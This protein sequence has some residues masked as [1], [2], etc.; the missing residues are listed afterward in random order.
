MAEY[1]TIFNHKWSKEVLELVEGTKL[2]P[3]MLELMMNWRAAV[4]THAFPGMMMKALVGLWEGTLRESGFT[5]RFVSVMSAEISRRMGGKM[6]NMA[7]KRLAQVIQDFADDVR[8]SLDNDPA[9]NLTADDMWEVFLHQDMWE[10][11]IAVW[12][13][14]RFCFGALYHAYESY[15]RE[16]LAIKKGKSDYRFRTFSDLVKHTTDEFGAGIADK[17]LGGDFLEVSRLVRNA[18]AHAGGKESKELVELRKTKD[19]G[20][21]VE[22]GFLQIMAPDNKLLISALEKRVALLTE[23]ALK[24]PEFR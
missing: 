5:M 21:Q 16:V 10:F 19:Y 2:D 15:F 20:I 12:G 11:Q 17:C 4:N 1:G 8:K 23:E 13:S 9:S 22:S 18:L 14:Q 24:Y 3:P 7:R 6:T